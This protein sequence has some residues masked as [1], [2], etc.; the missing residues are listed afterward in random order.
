MSE[1]FVPKRWWVSPL[2]FTVALITATVIVCKVSE[3]AREVL[4][5]A[6][7]MIAGAMATPFI[8]ESTIAI[9]GLVIVVAL[10]QWRLQKEGDG[11]VYL[12]QTEPDAASL[13]AGAETPAK[14]LEGVILTHAPDARIDLDARLGIAEGF[15]ELGLKQEALEHLNL[16]SEAE[17]KEPRAKAVRAKVEA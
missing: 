13:E 17:Q 15:L 3:T 4:A 11:W 2:I 9:V 1:A 10:N 12:A 8:L 16:L 5:K 14:R 7:M 6:V